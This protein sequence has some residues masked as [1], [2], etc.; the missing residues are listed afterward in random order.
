LKGEV[1]QA[2]VEPDECYLLG[3]DQ[4][5]TTP[6]LVIE[7]VWTSGG[8]N[9]LEI[10]RRLEVPEVWFWKDDA[11][12]I[13]FLHGD[14]YLVSSVSKG[15]PKLDTALLTAFLKHPTAMQAV[16]GYRAALSAK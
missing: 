10:Y 7:V 8:I 9:K 11:L 13:Y 15:L 6:D 16:R 3:A 12:C 1:K 14:R 5:R 2:G 4:E